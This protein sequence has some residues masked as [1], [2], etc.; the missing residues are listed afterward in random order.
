MQAEVKDAYWAVFDTEGL[1]K[2]GPKLV[3]PGN[4]ITE[5]AWP[6]LSDPPRR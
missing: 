5:M 6:V 1:A 4:R 2:P 3:E